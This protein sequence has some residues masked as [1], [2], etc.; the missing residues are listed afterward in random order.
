[1]IRPERDSVGYAMGLVRKHK[2]RLYDLEVKEHREKRSLD[3]NAYA[4]VLIG[5]LAQAMGIPPL[6]VYLSAIRGI[7]GN[8]EVLPVREEAVESFRRIWSGRG[9]GV[10]L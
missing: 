9:L 2:P 10:A 7:G 3:A 8:Y 5:K 1:M 6:D 4:W